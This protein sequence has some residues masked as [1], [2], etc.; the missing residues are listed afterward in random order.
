MV[1]TIDAGERRRLLADA[2]WRLM[3]WGGLEAASVRSVAAEAGLATGSVRHFFSTQDELHEFAMRELFRIVAERVQRVLAQPPEAFGSTTTADEGRGFSPGQARARVVAVLLETQPMSPE[4]SELFL[5]SLQFVSKAMVHP[6]L[7][8][9]ARETADLLHD[10]YRQLLEFL[11][12]TGAARA[13]LDIERT[14]G[15]LGVVLDG[16]AMRRLTAPHLLEVEDIRATV[17][18]FVDRL[19]GDQP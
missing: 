6:A 13:D 5:V 4:Q 2:V 18:T 11:V 8:P 7:R 1:R 12:Q 3:R 15:D 9:V 19:R 17:T 16:L 10:T 14:A